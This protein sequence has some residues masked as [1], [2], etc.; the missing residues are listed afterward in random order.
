[1]RCA[2][3]VA[4]RRTGTP[5]GVCRPVS[6]G[7][8]T[9]RT[10]WSCRNGHQRGGKLTMKR[11]WIVALALIGAAALVGLGIAIGRAGGG[12][13]NKGVTASGA[14][15]GAGKEEETV[16]TCSMHPQVRQAQ[17]G[18]CPI[19]GMDLIRLLDEQDEGIPGGQITVSEEAAALMEVRTWPVERRPVERKIDLFGHITYD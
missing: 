1:G 17:P 8:G 16:W 18:Q 5:A 6:A 3:D 11:S 12:H 13:P 7:S 10:G 14:A 9:R 2:A 4:R 19:C 15:A